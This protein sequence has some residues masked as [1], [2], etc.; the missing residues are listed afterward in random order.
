MSSRRPSVAG[1][2][3]LFHSSIE[4]MNRTLPE[5]VEGES[6]PKTASWR[7]HQGA[8]T[9]TNATTQ[10]TAAASE[11]AGRLAP[12]DR[13]ARHRSQ[14]KTRPREA[15]TSRPS[16]RDSVARPASRPAPMKAHGDDPRN[17]RAPSHREPM[18]SGWKR[19]KLSGW[20]R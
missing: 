6:D 8:M 12:A 18:T 16:L 11:I 15:R 13:Q 20:T 10:P 4:R 9:R 3:M 19:E 7:A 1:V 5:A 17:A 2:E 14:T